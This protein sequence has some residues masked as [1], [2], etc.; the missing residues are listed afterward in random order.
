MKKWE[1]NV[2]VHILLTKLRLIF[3][4]MDYLPDCVYSCYE[5]SLRDICREIDDA[6]YEPRSN[7]TCYQVL[8]KSEC[9]LFRMCHRS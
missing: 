2:K 4:A 5:C 6:R 1:P 7:K 9:F 3:E 8:G